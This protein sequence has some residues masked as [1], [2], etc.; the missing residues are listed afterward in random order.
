MPGRGRD[1]A[2]TLAE[3]PEI[4]TLEQVARYLGI[5]R[6]SA[7]AAAQRGELPTFRI[8]RLL[9]VSRHHLERL[10]QGRQTPAG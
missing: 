9:R 2:L 7:Y 1:E 3:L 10:V 4:M 8:G 5:G 6:R